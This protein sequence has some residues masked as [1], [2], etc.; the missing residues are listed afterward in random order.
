VIFDGERDGGAANP[1]YVV[2]KFNAL[3]SQLVAAATRNARTIVQQFAADSGASFGKIY[4]AN[5]GVIQIFGSDGN[6]ES[7][8]Y[9][10]P[11]KTKSASSALSRLN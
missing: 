8:L 7:G 5:Q 1:R 4:S 9:S 6:D 2:S 3:R 11:M 10:T